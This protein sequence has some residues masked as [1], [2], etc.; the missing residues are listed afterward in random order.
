MMRSKSA[1]DEII[2]DAELAAT[3]SLMTTEQTPSVDEDC[4]I[5]LKGLG[6]GIKW[7]LS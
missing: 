1:A 5:C 2:T 4:V 7:T 6:K 3:D